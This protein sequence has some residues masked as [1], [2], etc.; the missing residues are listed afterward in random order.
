MCFCVHSTWRHYVCH[1]LRLHTA[2]YTSCLISVTC[3]LDTAILF[4][5][6]RDKEFHLKLG[7]GDGFDDRSILKQRSF[8]SGSPEVIIRHSD[9]C[10]WFGVLPKSW[11]MPLV[12]C[13]AYI[14]LEKLQWTW[15]TLFVCCWINS[16]LKIFFLL[17]LLL[18]SFSFFF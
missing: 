15:A 4:S 18:T 17:T 3:L 9:A 11:W 5:S 12:F 16:N 2:V 13:N 1:I 14:V 8:I 6:V 10:L 7:S